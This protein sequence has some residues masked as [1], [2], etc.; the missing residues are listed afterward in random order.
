MSYIKFIHAFLKH[1][2]LV[3]TI[4]PSPILSNHVDLSQLSSQIHISFVIS[5]PSQYLE[6]LNC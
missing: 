4:L 6:I 2:E 3:N 5:I 1:K